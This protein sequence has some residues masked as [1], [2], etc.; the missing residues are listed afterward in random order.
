MGEQ[1]QGTPTRWYVPSG[2]GGSQISGVYVTDTTSRS[3][4]ATFEELQV[5]GAVRDRKRTLLPDPSP[6]EIKY[7][8][9]SVDDHVL[10][11]P[12]LFE[13]R[14]PAQLV[15]QAPKIVRNEPRGDFWEIEGVL[16]GMGDWNG[17]SG[18][19]MNEWSTEPLQYD[20]LRR[21]VW[22]PKER[23]RDM[24]LAGIIASVCFP[25]GIWGFAGQKFMR[26]KDQNLG[27]ACMRAYNDWVVEEWS[28]TD[29]DRL[30]SYQ[31]PWYHDMEIAAQEVMRNA[32]RGVKCVTFSENP[33][34]IGMPSLYSKYWD[35]FFR[36]CEETGTVINLHVGS[37][38]QISKPSK[39]SP[40]EASLA[41]FGAN[42]MLAS[43][44]WL[45]AQIPVRFPKLKIVYS[46]SGIGFLPMLLDRLE[47]IQMYREY[48]LLQF[49]WTD[50]ELAPVDV[51]RRNFWFSTFWDPI[52]FGVI[53]GIGAHRVLLEVDYPHPDSIWPDVQGRCDRQLANLS[54]PLIDAVTHGNAADLFGIPVE[55]LI[56][57]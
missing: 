7:H 11:P 19:P 49:S 37:S 12:T 14:L 25:S 21:G 43:I 8:V 46:E 22:D 17:A 18:R 30:I 23:L 3:E 57:R 29:P 47:H 44:D 45:Y 20:E 26:M 35:P 6:S 28:A 1:I 15:E 34:K 9:V 41:L 39:D 53:E 5:R 2:G 50:K 36:T 16:E 40:E 48:E 54:K 31:V 38:S 56:G 13:G 51:F 27:L 10:E 55:K 24:D 52:A 33:E 32:S 42:S 4:V